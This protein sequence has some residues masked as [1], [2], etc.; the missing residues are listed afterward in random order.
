MSNIKALT[1]NAYYDGN[2]AQD[3][4][5]NNP[6]ADID[7]ILIP[8]IENNFDNY[9][10]YIGLSNPSSIAPSIWVKIMEKNQDV[11]PANRSHLRQGYSNGFYFTQAGGVNQYGQGFSFPGFQYKEII[12]NTIQDSNYNGVSYIVDYLEN[13][14]QNPTWTAYAPGSNMELFPLDSSLTNDSVSFLDTERYARDNLPYYMNTTTRLVTSQSYLNY[15][16]DYVVHYDNHTYTFTLNDDFP[17]YYGFINNTVY[18]PPTTND[19]G[20]NQFGYTANQIKIDDLGSHAIKTIN[21][22]LNTAFKNDFC[23]TDVNNYAN[24][25]NFLNS[26]LMIDFNLPSAPPF[27]QEHYY[28]LTYRVH[29]QNLY[30]PVNASINSGLVSM[31]IHIKK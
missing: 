12:F 24:Q 15:T 25:E 17:T 23:Y 13:W 22:P 2:Y 18:I 29:S 16:A 5:Q 11:I 9:Y 10:V 31:P 27:Y 26:Q 20:D 21:C 8:Y 6:V 3:I 14:L 7:N 19:L 1:I 28:I 30:L 4:L